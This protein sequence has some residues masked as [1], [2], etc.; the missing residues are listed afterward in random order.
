MSSWLDTETKSLLS[1]EPPNKLAPSD[2][3]EFSLVVLEC[4]DAESERAQRAVERIC[5]G[6]HWIAKEN[7]GNASPFVLQHGLSEADA[8]LGQFE[9]ICCNIVSV[10]IPDEVIENA[11]PEYLSELYATLLDSSEF[12]N[13]KLRIGSL[14]DNTQGA[15]FIVQFLGKEPLSCPVEIEV[16]FKKARIMTHWASKIGAE[17]LLL[18]R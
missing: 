5:Q 8:L 1:K 4:N 17:V 11:K 12:T 13:T 18:A 3:A 14:P 6:S 7:L 15:E 2:I 10:F 9:L 16:P